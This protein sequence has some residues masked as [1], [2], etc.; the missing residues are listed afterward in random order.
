MTIYIALRPGDLLRIRERD[1]DLEGGYIAVQNPTKSDEPKI[2]PILEADV[3]FVSALPV[4]FPDL[5]FFR[6][7]AGMKGVRA[8]A[9]FGE[10]YLYK[11]WK[12]ACANL[13]IEGVDLYGGTRHSSARALRKYRSPEEI[14]RA[15]GH[16]TNKAFD[17]YFQIE[18]ED[19]REIYQDAE[20][21]K[22]LTRKNRP[23]KNAKVLKLKE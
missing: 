18:A 23:I 15:T 13:G 11:W 7:P 16:H 8:G 6:H 21:D 19:M 2:I 5:S 14:K 4:A 1:I 20:T 10:K 17:R 12:K 9:P 3:E 22:K